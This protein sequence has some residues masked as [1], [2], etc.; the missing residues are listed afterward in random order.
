MG[1]AGCLLWGKM[2]SP[3]GN[4]VLTLSITPDLFKRQSGPRKSE[5]AVPQCVLTC[6]YGDSHTLN[7]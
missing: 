4:W 5:H 7:T 3:L 6:L 2:G 1:R